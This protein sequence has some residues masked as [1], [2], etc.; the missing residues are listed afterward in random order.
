MHFAKMILLCGVVLTQAS[1]STLHVTRANESGK[2]VRIGGIPFVSKVPH[3]IQTT[4]W[5][6]IESYSISGTLTVRS[7]K[8]G[9][10][11]DTDVKI[12]DPPLVI[13]ATP[14]TRAAALE[15]IKEVEKSR[16]TFKTSPDK[17]VAWFRGRVVD[18]AD[19][20]KDDEPPLKADMVSNVEGIEMVIDPTRYYL[21]PRMPFLG[22]ATHTFKLAADGT[23]T[24]STTTATDETGKTLLG[25]LPVSA[26]LTKRWVGSGNTTMGVKEEEDPPAASIA[27]FELT[28]D[29]EAVIYQ[30]RARCPYEP[31]DKPTCKLPAKVEL[32]DAQSPRPAGDSTYRVELVS[33]TRAGA[34]AKKPEAPG[35][36]ISGR[37]TL[38]TP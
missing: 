34:E 16:I 29:Q 32:V 11:T 8:A 25:M 12:F 7:I 1:C 3:R 13:R 23:L 33:V 37:I 24:D 2:E 27:A 9:V 28:V 14:S 38:P 18:L 20:A 15:L 17:F 19:L 21:K 6:R 10:P 4:S 31:G 5:S 36:G 30:A 35:Y 22:S 26:F